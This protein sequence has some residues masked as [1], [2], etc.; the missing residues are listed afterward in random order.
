MSKIREM[1][2]VL[3]FSLIIFPQSMAF[4]QE[5]ALIVP[6]EYFLLV[7][8]DP[9]YARPQSDRSHWQRYSYTGLPLTSDIFW[10]Q[11]DF[12]VPSDST[13][14][15]GVLVSLLGSYDAYWDGRYVGSNG[16]VGN[17]KSEEVPGQ[18]DKV[19][20]LPSDIVRKG[21]HTLSLRISSQH[22]LEGQLTGSFWSFL[23][24][25]DYLVQ[26]PY[27][28]ASRPMVM[29]GAL[30]LVAL[31]T[32]FLY[33]T[34]LRQPS[35]LLFSML[36]FV[37]LCLI[38][39]ESWRG[40]WGYTYDW[41][42][43]RL[44]IVLGLSTIIGVLLTWFMAWFF[45]LSRRSRFMWLIGSGVLQMI[46]LIAV[47]GY[48]APSLYVFLI[49]AL[50]AC[51]I[52]MQAW[53][54]KQP[55]A[56]IMLMGLLLFLAPIFVNTISY[57][58]HYF[59]VSFAALMG[60]MLYT[61][62][63]TMEMKQKALAQSQINAS[64]LE[65]ELVKRQL[66]PHFILNTLTAIEEWIEESPATAVK[67]IQALA[68]EFRYMA[69]MSSHKRIALHD[70]INLCRS[71][72]KVMSYRTNVQFS[73]KVN[74]Q[75]KSLSIPPGVLLT[76]LENAISHNYY[77]HGDI[78]FMLSQ[79]LSDQGSQSLLLVVPVSSKT[80]KGY[81]ETG[82]S[83]GIGNQYIEARMKESF[84]DMWSMQT[85]LEEDSWQVKLTFPQFGQNALNSEQSA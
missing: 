8:D 9:D 33:V 52:C 1:I 23:S 40:L 20:L 62:A 58:D 42:I 81:D 51:G 77:R 21:K 53:R 82:I 72:L 46:I 12:E 83:L 2:V 85:Q 78:E 27:K 44:W 28:Q 34:V 10:V 38:L 14:A 18:I 55:Y 76:F 68:D 7:D 3:L 43:P 32:L 29:S 30:L 66:Q 56:L 24:D 26:I 31:Y 36:C 59:F 63:K 74:V 67:F 50:T 80:K 17:N 45:P 64:R 4:V 6:T 79:Q 57:M 39:A 25:Y 75:N 61:L 41:Q 48:D 84:E 49:G 15:M 54:Q 70:E 73:L 60:L 5:P 13:Q 69:D 19:F 22:R 37:I 65:L 11:Y 47:D 71:H 16:V 35:Y